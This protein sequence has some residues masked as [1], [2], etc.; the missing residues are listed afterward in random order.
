MTRFC[1]GIRGF[2]QHHWVFG[3]IE[4]IRTC[5]MAVLSRLSLMCSVSLYFAF[6]Y[7]EHL[8]MDACVP[9]SQEGLAAFWRGNVVNVIR[10]FPTQALNFAFKDTYN[11]L[12]M[13]LGRSSYSYWEQF[14]RG[15]LAGGAAGATALPFVFPLDLCR[16][17]LSTDQKDAAGNRRYRGL[18]HVAKETVRTGGVKGLYKGFGIACI[19]I[20]PYRA[21]YFGGVRAAPLVL[22]ALPC[23]RSVACLCSMT[24]SSRCSC[25]TLTAPSH[26]GSSGSFRKRIRSW[27]SF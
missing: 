2:M 11:D 9:R 10:Y 27:H 22:C 20:V 13:P 25:P 5:P 23:V 21:V 12:L 1:C 26:F 8:G 15:L 16:T 6:V 19:G 14:G 3:A 7:G 17:R 18:V 4:L 24:R